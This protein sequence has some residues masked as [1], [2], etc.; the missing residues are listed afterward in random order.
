MTVK[1]TLM[2]CL[3]L[4]HQLKD[5]EENKGN[6]GAVSE[7]AEDEDGLEDDGSDDDSTDNDDDSYQEHAVDVDLI[8]LPIFTQDL[9]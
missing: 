9:L 3:M 1:I 2:N 6:T 7:E 8:V 5:N 4:C